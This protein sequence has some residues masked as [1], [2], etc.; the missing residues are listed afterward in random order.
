VFFWGSQTDREE[1]KIF[2]KGK[3]KLH[4]FHLSFKKR[5]KIHEQQQKNKK[6]RN[7]VHER[8]QAV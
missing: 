8:E 3:K 6:K 4:H 2:T 7:I 1:N 5:K